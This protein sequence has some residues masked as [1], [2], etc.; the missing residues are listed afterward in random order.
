MLTLDENGYIT[1]DKPVIVDYETFVGE[2]VVNDHR[3]E[4]FSEYKSMLQ[5]LSELLGKDFHQWINGSFIST[6][7]N[8]A[9]IDLVNLIDHHVVDQHESD[10][11]RFTASEAKETFGIDAYIVKIYPQDHPFSVRTQ[12]DV[13]YWEHW[14]SN[15][16]KNRRR[17][18]FPKG[19]IEL[20]H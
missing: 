13:K 17:V 4:I 7:K 15:S 8:P 9:D 20:Q 12:S 1:P 10:L 18:R 3:A 6:E 2:F 11:V 19:F 5:G 14:F 16:R